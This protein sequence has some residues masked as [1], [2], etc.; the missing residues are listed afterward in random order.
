[1]ARLLDLSSPEVMIAGPAE[2][3]KTFGCL[4]ILDYRCR[5]YPNTQ[6]L[7]LRKTYNSA[8]TSVIQTWERKII[9]KD[10]KPFGGVHP[11]LYVYPNGS[12]V[13]V[14][15]MDNPNKVLSSERDFIYVNQAEELEL[16]EWETLTTRATGRAGNAPFAQT[17]GDCNPSV[18]THFLKTRQS[19]QLLESRHEDNPTLFSDSGVITDQ[20][21][22]TL[23]ILD[24]LTGPRKQRLRYGRWVQAEG[25]VY[26]GWDAAVHLM[27]WS[28]LPGGKIPLSWRRFL[29]VDFGFVH[30]FVALWFAQDED[31][32]LYLYREIHHTGRLVE[33]HAKQIKA[34]ILADGVRPSSIICDHDA[35]DRATLEKHLGQSTIAAPKAVS[36]GLQAVASRLRRQPDGRPRFFVLRDS[37]VERDATLHDARKPCCF[38]EEIDGYIWLDNARRDEPVKELDDAMDAARYIVYHLDKRPSG[39][40]LERF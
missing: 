6:A 11:Q 29:S 4:S 15:G 27:D 2:T 5:L 35:E 30:P 21:R 9:G 13:L 37:L 7:I 31:G 22:R 10:V 1:M 26:E 20:G 33:D 12:Q 14:G 19:L 36:P 18:P 16:D 3:G 28:A 40:K 8:V 24:A 39:W 23:A 17:F 34:F 38:S 32:R 25:V